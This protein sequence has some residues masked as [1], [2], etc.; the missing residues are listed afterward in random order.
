M[1]AA[2]HKCVGPA[3]HDRR[4]GTLETCCRQ[5]EMLRLQNRDVDWAQHQI[6]VRGANAKDSENRR[7]PFDPTRA[8]RSD[9][10][11]PGC[12][13]AGTRSSS[14]RQTGRSRT[15]SRP[16]GSLSRCSPT[17]TI[18]RAPSRVYASI[19]RSSGKIDLHW[20]DLRH[21]GACRLLATVSIF[22]PSN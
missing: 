2:E 17:G 7:I 6:V 20:H 4:I 11:A 12:S 3:M 22:G 14:A 9:P 5:G 10:E 19:A 21:E 13:W 18:R 8:V 15:A 1:N 16:P